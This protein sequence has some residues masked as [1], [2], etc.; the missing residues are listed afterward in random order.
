MNFRDSLKL[1]ALTEAVFGEWFD[2]RMYANFTGL[3]V[4]LASN[5]LRRL[6][7][8]GFLK[9]RR[10]KRI[11]ITKNGKKCFRGYEYKYSISKQGWNYLKYMTGGE[12]KTH[13]KFMLDLAVQRQIENRY[14][15]NYQNIAWQV[16]KI[17]NMGKG[18]KRFSTSEKKLLEMIVE[19]RWKLIRDETILNLKKRIEELEKKFEEERKLREKAEEER[20]QALK[21]R[22]QACLLLKQMMNSTSKL[23]EYLTQR[24]LM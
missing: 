10:V 2:S 24:I 16:W 4:K 21:E 1:V 20:D 14:Q 22:D 9:Y 3:P 5:E 19:Y 15:E 6:Y 11:C 18:L 8:M 23:R 17:A 12:N 13:E 7:R